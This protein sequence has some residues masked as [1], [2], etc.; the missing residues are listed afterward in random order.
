MIVE[1]LEHLYK[2]RKDFLLMVGVN[3]AVAVACLTGSCEP[4]YFYEPYKDVG[5]KVYELKQ[6][7]LEYLGFESN[8]PIP[9]VREL[10]AEELRE[11]NSTTKPTLDN[12]IKE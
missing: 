5:Y 6:G 9:E 4:K 7:K 12:F 10:T 3:T 2:T 8:K 1:K 11:Q